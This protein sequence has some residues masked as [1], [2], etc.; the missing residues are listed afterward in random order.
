M[1]GVTHKSSWVHLHA[2]KLWGI[3]NGD[4]GKRLKLENLF[5]S[6]K[7]LFC[8]SCGPLSSPPYRVGIG[9]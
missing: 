2:G 1:D 5:R 4:A 9:T 8:R 3:E 7:R 6:K